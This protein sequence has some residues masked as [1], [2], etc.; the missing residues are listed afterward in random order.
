MANCVDYAALSVSSTAVTLLTDASPTLP[1]GAKGALITVETDAVRW[2]ADGTAPTASEGTY[3]SALGSLTL[4]SWTAGPQGQRNDW[5]SVLRA[6]QFIR[7]TNDA[8]VKV[9]FFD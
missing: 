3:I 7:V 2:R 1:A 5:R 8:K 9:H 4:D 6:I